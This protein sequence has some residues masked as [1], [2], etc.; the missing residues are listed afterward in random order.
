MAPPETQEDDDPLNCNEQQALPSLTSPRFVLLLM[1][2]FVYG[3]G[4]ST[5]LLLPKYLTQ[6]HHADAQLI[7][8]LMAA[9][10][11]AS[12]LV[13]PF[14][15]P[16]IDRV[17]RHHLLFWSALITMAGSLGFAALDGLG[18]IAYALRALHGA[19]FTVFG[20]TTLT[21]AVDL[22]PKDRLGQAMGLIG[23]ANLATNALGPSIAEPA[24]EIWGWHAVFTLSALFSLMSALG[25]LA[26]RERRALASR[27]ET[28]KLGITPRFGRLLYSGIMVG[29]SFG[30]VFTF[31]QP[32]ALE[33]GIRDLS[34]WFVGYT[35]SALGVR[36]FGGTLIDRLDRKKL[37]LGASAL[38]AAS[39]LATALLQPGWLFVLG[40]ILGLA[41]G[42][43]WPVLTALTVEGSTSKTRSALLTYI[44]GSFNVGVIMSTLGFGMIA[45][46]LGYRSV[47]ALA[48]LLA[49][50][51]SLVLS[52]LGDAP[53]PESTRL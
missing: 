36:V 25:A 53:Q 32:L 44:S 21:L 17:S 14:V 34:H 19:A 50:S 51:S 1:V 2:Q 13:L 28:V 41:H 5:F 4:F 6:V 45:H 12:V 49:V 38:Y 7:G 11:V 30:T 37:S 43:L 35:L 16:R 10:P 3:L 18:P 46:L 48:G 23:A 20:A 29:V 31:Y 24:S 40:F 47:I 22:A 27:T 42:T 33:L 52:R 8:H 9:S 39:V 26:F 15:A